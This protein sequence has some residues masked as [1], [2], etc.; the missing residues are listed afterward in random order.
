MGF[1]GQDLRYAVRML[2][3]SPAFT[4]MAVLTLAIGIGAN[5]AIFTVLNAVLLRPLPFHD[6]GNLLI[7][8]ETSTQFGDDMGSVAY[9]NFTDW[10]AQNSTL[11]SMALFRHR[12]IT[13][14]SDRGPE[15]IDGREVSARFFNILGVPLE[16]GRDIEPQDDHEGSGPVAILS[17]GLWQR[18]FGGDRG[19]IG[20]P[21]HLN[22][23]NYTIVGVTGKDLWF[24][25]P[26]D[27]YTPI[28][29]SGQMWLTNRLEREG[30]YAVARLKPGVSPAQAGSDLQRIAQRLAA[31]YP[32]ANA[33]HGVKAEVMLDNVVHDVRKTLLLLFGAVVL[34]LTIACVNVANLLLSRIVPRQ[35]ELAVRAALGASRARVMVQLLTESVL[36][37]LTGGLLG[38]GVAWAGTRG[39]LSAVPHTLPRTSDIGVDWRVALF[40][41]GLCLVTGILFGLAPVWQ[42]FRGNLNA[43]LKEGGRVAGTGRQRLQNALVISE[44]ALALLLLVGSGLTLRSLQKLGK[45]N[46]GFV[47][48]NVVTFDIGFSKLRY[49]QPQKIRSLFRQVTDRM[50]AAPG[51]EGAALTTNV[52][53]R[54]DSEVMFYI[55]ERPKPEPKDYEWS[56]MYI[57]SPGYVRTMG[58]TLLKGRFYDEHDD[59]NGHEVLVI[60]D[61]LARSLFPG[62]EAIGQHIIIPFPGLEQ[63]REIIGIV[64][65]VAQWGLAQDS[66]AK[67]RSEFYMPFLQVPEK[68]YSMLNGMTFAARSP[69]PAQAA[70]KAVGDELRAIDSDMPVY[71]IQTMNEIISLSIARERF[72]GLLFGIFAGAALL[73]GAIGTYGVLSY[74]VSQRTRE[75][76]VRMALGAQSADIISLVFGRGAKLIATGVAI[77]LLA[78][79]GLS[80]LRASLLYGVKATDPVI[81]AV[82]AVVLMIVAAIACYIPARRA[83]K[84]DPMVTLR[85]E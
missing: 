34:L 62:Q 46:T 51:I 4:V 47:P 53:M 55:A 64:G 74:L 30:A 50:A 80:R 42:S 45:V 26:A 16:L 19:V 60:D 6:P 15:H 27:V 38:I 84:V 61:V 11:Q 49:D 22:D 9:Q 72:A 82:V 1:F 3:K 35:K 70:A 75:M 14:S 67:I 5:T 39:L 23:K 71:N 83:T 2:V 33:G 28:G 7:L 57:T 25:T 54:D 18:R 77:G 17:Y 41:F 37:S 69:L 52:M 81:F 63:P 12:D 8:G 79:F 73:L 20:R 76:G 68:F 65:H 59:L 58:L 32:E 36:L 21:I 44:L 78:A 40:L 66:T 29:A 10:Q 85:C 24:F 48:D 13:L 43:T 31:A 56:M